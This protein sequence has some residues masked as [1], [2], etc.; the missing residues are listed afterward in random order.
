MSDHPE[1]MVP[2][3]IGALPTPRLPFLSPAPCDNNVAINQTLVACR[4][5]R[6]VARL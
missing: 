3:P 4:V 2:V 6:A 1:L 5:F